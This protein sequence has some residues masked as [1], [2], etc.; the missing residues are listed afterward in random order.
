MYKNYLFTAIMALSVG[1][2][3]ASNGPKKEGF[4]QRGLEAMSLNDTQKK[5]IEEIYSKK[6]E[7]IL[8]L[9]NSMSEKSDALDK[10]LKSE[11]TDNELKQKF[12]DLVK[13]QDEFANARFEVM[14]SIRG[15]LTPDQR[16]KLQPHLMIK[17]GGPGNK[18]HERD[19]GRRHHDRE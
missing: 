1:Q 6:K 3:N 9:K 7:T 11:T 2:V 14:L 12:K 19:Y 10:S 5:Q 15:I 13:V 16:S 4:H 18:G 8:K 17:E